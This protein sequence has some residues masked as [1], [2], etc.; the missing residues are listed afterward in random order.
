MHE[1]ITNLEPIKMH[2]LEYSLT[3]IYYV[4]AAMSLWFSALVLKYLAMVA[5][6]NQ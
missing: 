3:I 2:L 1:Q 4:Y 5:E 6:Y